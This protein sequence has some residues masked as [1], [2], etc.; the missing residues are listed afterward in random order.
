MAYLY[1]HI[2]LDKNEPFYIGIGSDL[3]Y[4]RAYDLKNDRRNYIW[5]K[6]KQKTKIEVEIILDNLTWE[7]ACEK[8]MYFIKL[9]GRIDNKNGILSNLTNGGDGS[10]GFI[11]PEYRRQMLSEK[12][13]GKGNPMFGKKMPKVSIEKTRLK[14][15]GRIPWNKGKV[16]IY[17][18]DTKIKMGK[19][20]IGK[21]AWN[22]DKK[23]VNGIS[24]A[25]LVINL[26]N[27]IFYQS[28]KEAAL[29]YNVKHSTLKSKLNEWNRNNS[30][31]IYA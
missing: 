16:G 9:Y 14:N 17:S 21:T 4:N 19:S 2:R 6:I 1:R 26:E 25:K 7:Q 30:S 11:M 28:C 29:T 22:K 8:E 23:G 20:K 5:N 24:N 12:F 27:G 13:K 15:I 31:F 3:H 10:L 18:E